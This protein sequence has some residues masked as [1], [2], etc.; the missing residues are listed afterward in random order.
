MAVAARSGTT[1]SCD[2]VVPKG[3]DAGRWKIRPI[4]EFGNCV[5]IDVNSAH[6]ITAVG[7]VAGSAPPD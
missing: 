6:C 1:A 5:S 7:E 2:A 4:E 3:C